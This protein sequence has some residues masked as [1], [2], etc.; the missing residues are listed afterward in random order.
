MIDASGLVED[1]VVLTGRTN[2]DLSLARVAGRLTL[3]TLAVDS[4]LAVAA[5]TLLSANAVF[6]QHET[7]LAG[8]ASIDVTYASDTIL[9]TG[10]A[11]SGIWLV[12]LDVWLASFE[13]VLVEGVESHVVVTACALS[14]ISFTGLALGLASVTLV[15]LEDAQ[16]F[17]ALFMAV[18]IKVVRGLTTIHASCTV[19]G[20]HTASGT[21][22]LARL[23]HVLTRSLDVARSTPDDA[24]SISEMQI[25]A[26][27]ATCADVFGARA[28]EAGWVAQLAPQSFL[29]V[30]ASIRTLRKTRV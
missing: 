29:V 10:C 12:N 20:A 7:L 26:D 19:G 23:A 18:E 6:I 13:A 8:G 27:T 1:K 30:V 3:P 11:F 2:V 16:S 24:L 15:V 17:R 4:C 5:F 22:R 14:N 9:M 21:S 28:G 25:I